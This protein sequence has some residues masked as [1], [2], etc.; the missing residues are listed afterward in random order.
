MWIGVLTLVLSIIS[1]CTGTSFAKTLFSEVGAVGTTTFR[2]FF[3]ACILWLI[4]RPWRIPVTRSDLATIVPYGICIVGMNLPFYLA[5]QTLPVGI[6]LAIEFTGPLSLAIYK[7]RTRFDFLWIAFAM[8]G[9]YL[10]L[11]PNSDSGELIALDLAGVTYAIIAGAF[12]AAYIIFGQSA[13]R[14]HPGHVTSYGLTIAAMLILPFGLISGGANMFNTNLLLFGLAIAV[15]SSALPYSLEVFALRILP[16]KTFSI[17]LSLEPAVGA[18]AGIII[19][20]EVIE[21]KQWI[22]ILLVVSASA[23]CTATAV[24]DNRR[25]KAKKKPKSLTNSNV[26]VF[27]SLPYLRITF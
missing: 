5:L 11:W 7:S 25:E 9:L 15:L 10:L 6:A 1:L 24:R 2:I 13:R 12:W 8:V 23:G 18:L 21:S 26:N 27:L 16:A 17:M 14:V 3:S 20:G 4:W 19:L 22:A